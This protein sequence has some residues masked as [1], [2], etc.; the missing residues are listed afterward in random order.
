MADAPQ[1]VQ[2]LNR[3][4]GV[5]G[6]LAFVL[7][8]ATIGVSIY[9][10]THPE[11][12]PAPPAAQAT[13]PRHLIL[14]S[15]DT[16]RADHLGCYGYKHPVSPAIDALAREGA[17]FENYYTCYPLT[18]PSHLTQLTGVSTLGHRVRDNLY[19]SLPDGLSLLQERLSAN[20][21]RCGAFVS[22]HTMRAG[23]GIERGF[24][25][26]DDA[27]VREAA[28]GRLTVSERKAPETLQ[29]AADWLGRTRDT[30]LF[31]Y[32]HLFDPH[33][34]YQPHPDLGID[35]T[36]SAHALYD[37]EIAYTDR[38]LSRF[39]VKLGELGLMKDSLIVVTAD[40]GEGLGEHDELTHGYFCYDTTTHIPLVV[41]GAPGIAAGTRVPALTRNY[42][43]APTL[44]EL[45][46]VRD[47]AMARQAHGISLVPTLKDPAHDPGL[48]V[49]VESHYAW[50]NAH[51]AKVRG[52]RTR[53]G[54]ALF[55]G[56]QAEYVGS[57][58][59]EAALGAARDEITRLLN[60]WLPPRGGSGTLREAAGGSPYP[61]E[62]P[63]A[64]VFDPESLH[65]TRDLPSPMQVAH[66]LRAYQQAELAYDE[67]RFEA[68]ASRLRELLKD[69]PDFLMGHRVL[70]AVLQGLVVR[71][72][73]ALGAEQSAALTRE[74]AAAV[75]ITAELCEKNG[76]PE[77]ALGA[78]RNLMLLAVWLNDRELALAARADTAELQW[79]QCLLD[80]RQACDAGT[81][82]DAAARAGKA[83]A[84]QEAAARAGKALESAIFSDAGRKA[85][86]GHL[87]TMQQ[88]RPLLLAP[89]ER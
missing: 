61:G 55:A 28:P 18:L 59:R 88:G 50:L 30:R 34:P 22:A 87:E 78:R 79:L 76:Q 89:W 74:A 21:F 48:S 20:G 67:E 2:F 36:G 9:R 39:F 33:A 11:A 41:R 85:A 71:E 13:A 4:G 24:E 12:P 51:W 46:D 5:W 62:A 27:A 42:D 56:K 63:S 25:V 3:R 40:H 52:L 47:E 81:Q 80:Y 7:V 15:I 1:K 44:L 35:L 84:K 49:F 26:Y 65:D 32:I 16:L 37:G 29:L 70:A 53:D 86:Q 14:I 8:A 69:Q 77:A 6:V 23:S 83:G 72:A 66:V 58:D 82:Q 54:L 68:C 38:E 31:C 43:L 10:A 17:L 73:G 75:R 19:H 60:S 64:Q 57:G 45:L